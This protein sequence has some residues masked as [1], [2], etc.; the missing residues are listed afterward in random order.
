VSL[1]ILLPKSELVVL[2]EFISVEVY[3]Y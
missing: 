2:T 1:A 3:D